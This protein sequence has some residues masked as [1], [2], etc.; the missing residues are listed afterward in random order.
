MFLDDNSFGSSIQGFGDANGGTLMYASIDI[1]FGPFIDVPGNP[2]APVAA[3][4]NQNYPNPFNPTTNISYELQQAQPV[5]LQ[6]YNTKGQLVKTLV[7]ETQTEGVHNVV[8]NGDDN[9]GNSVTSGVYF[10][11]MKS[12]TFE[13]ARKMILMK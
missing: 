1:D 8:W 9:S 3:S 4:L 5:V 6:V 10:Y 7:N 13:S 2:V 12:S 11:K